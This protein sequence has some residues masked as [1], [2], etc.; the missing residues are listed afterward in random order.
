[1]PQARLRALQQNLQTLVERPE[2]RALVVACA[3]PEVF[4]V[5]Q[6]LEQMDEQ[7]ASN[8]FC[9]LADPFTTAEDYADMLESLVQSAIELPFTPSPDSAPAPRVMAALEHMLADLPHGDHNLVVAFIPAQIKDCPAFSAIVEALLDGPFDPRLRLVLRDDRLASQHLFTKAAESSSEQIFAC[10]FA[11][12]P[13][14]LLADIAALAHD[15]TRPPD[16]RALALIELSCND[17]TQ[18]RPA[19]AITRCEAIA[20]LPAHATLQALAMATQADAMRS[21]QDVDAAAAMG[22]AALQLAV[23]SDALPVVQHAALALGDLMRQSGRIAEADA[24]LA[25]AEQ[26]SSSN[27][28][29]K[30]HIHSLRSELMETPCLSS[31]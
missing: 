30:A 11:L 6:L 17:L 5:A 26:S 22:V 2:P 19:D 31:I 25:L 1:M 18:G 15:P 20:R 16:E 7:S 12:P 27:P 3:D 23:D 29:L 13:E 14:I 21:L 10:I 24:C 4:Y 9:L 28:E 8:R